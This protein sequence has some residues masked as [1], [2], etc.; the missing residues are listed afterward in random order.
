VAWRPQLHPDRFSPRCGSNGLSNVDI[1][2]SPANRGSA[3]PATTDTQQQA[4]HGGLGGPAPVPQAVLARFLQSTSE[5][6]YEMSWNATV[7]G[8]NYEVS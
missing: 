8:G 1:A 2:F 4:C 5:A 3:N 6:H 7:R